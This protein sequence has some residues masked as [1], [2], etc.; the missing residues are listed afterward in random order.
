[1]GERLN[2]QPL[3]FYLLPLCVNGLAFML[4]GGKGFSKHPVVMK[5]YTD[6][7]SATGGHQGQDHQ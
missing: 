4:V 6:K 2:L 7:G 3:L 5:R 1:M